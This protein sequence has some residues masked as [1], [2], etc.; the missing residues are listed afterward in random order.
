MAVTLHDVAA[1]AGVS[2]KTVSNV[3]NGYRRI[4]PERVTGY[5]RP[6]ASSTTS[7][8]CPREAC[9]PAAPA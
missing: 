8:T 5:S 7:P 6:S 1:I 3:V 9:D 4:H 2:I